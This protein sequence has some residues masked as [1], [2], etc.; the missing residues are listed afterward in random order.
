VAFK[1]INQ[2]V[3]DVDSS[4][5]TQLQSA[6]GQDIAL[7]PDQNVWIKQG[8]KVIFEG[9]T[10]DD[11]E[12]KLQATT[13]T[14]DR[15]LILPDESGTLATQSYVTSAISGGSLADT[16][17]L[18]EGSSNL[19][20]T[21]GRVD[22][23]IAS[24]N[25]SDL[26]DIDD[27]ARAD[28]YV[29]TWENAT[30]TWI[31]APT[32]STY[33]TS[34]FNTD[35]ATALG[36]NVTIGGNL[37]VSGTT[38]TVNSNTVNI[39]DAIITLNADETG[40]PSQNAGI[41]VER[42]TE[43]NVFI[44]Y[45]ESTNVWEFTNDGSAYTAF[46]SSSTFTGNTDGISEGSANLYYTDARARA[47]ISATGSISYNNTTGVISYTQPT[48]VSTFTNDSG[49]I[50]GYTVTSGDVTG[51][52]GYT[53]YNATN[54]NG[55][56][57]ASS[58]DT[59]TNKTLGAT[60]VAGH[61]IPDTDVSY[62]LGSTTFKFRD[63]Y[64]SGTTI[65]LGGATL[66]ADGSNLS[67]GSGAFDLAQN[68]TAD[69]AEHT[70]AQYYTDTKVRTHIEGAD[71]NLGTNKI[72]Y[73]NVYATTGDLPSASS[74][75]GMFAHVHAEGKGYF[76]HSGAWKELVDTSS[77]SGINIQFNSIG[78][79]TAASGT[80]GDIRATAD[81]TAYY[82]SD[83]KLKENVVEIDNAINKVKQIRGV[84]FDWTQDYL[85]A[86]GGEDNYFIRK[87]DVGV[88]A[89][90]IETVLPEVVGTREDGIKAVKYDRIVALL[91]QAVK[92]QQS[93]IDDLKSQIQNIQR[94]E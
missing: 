94:G 54:P 64:L 92:E 31:A 83:E 57:T 91:I 60:T 11:Y 20:Y 72:T 42:G 9:T 13:V 2:T 28:T 36:G 87:H 32:A 24:A 68:T 47:A 10:P 75:H 39:G 70:T 18:A 49:Y 22:L 16:D 33:G 85:E 52:L 6:S 8:T 35:L 58:T 43:A 69:L 81:V 53:P 76:A 19:Y 30:S 26:A 4:G 77:S 25:L 41:E 71:L 93:E 63:L 88:I 67:L 37:T 86:K 46:G 17:A 7:Y 14:A 74:Y 66:S 59:L 84:E 50:T 12:A 51:A 40:T 1:V 73:S 89:Q 27:S 48:N 62:D 55:Y 38:T 82:S 45:N 5:A 56:I 3:I 78:A 90:E 65:S 79:G 44:R 29:L 21:D 80:A 61:I 23:R 34:D 15:D